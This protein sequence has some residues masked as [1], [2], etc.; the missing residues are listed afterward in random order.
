MNTGKLKQGQ[1]LSAVGTP[2]H[3][4]EGTHPHTA[5][6]FGCKSITVSQL[7]GPMGFYDCAHIEFEDGAVSIKE[8]LIPLH[9]CDYIAL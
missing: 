4:A 6:Q 1:N 8:M 2:D 5:G 7:R 9:Q 3:N